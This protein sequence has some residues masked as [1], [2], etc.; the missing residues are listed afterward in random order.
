MVLSRTSKMLQHIVRQ[1]ATGS[2]QQPSVENDKMNQG[3]LHPHA[4]LKRKNSFLCHYVWNAASL[5]FIDI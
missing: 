5:F 1:L 4:F 3:Q 2:W